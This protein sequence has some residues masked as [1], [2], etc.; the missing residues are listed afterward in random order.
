MYFH[1]IIHQAHRP[2][3]AGVRHWKCSSQTGYRQIQDGGHFGGC[4][5][6]LWVNLC[7][8]QLFWIDG[9]IIKSI[10]LVTNAI[11][12]MDSWIQLT[13]KK[14]LP[15]LCA[16]MMCRIWL[17]WLCLC[18]LSG[19]GSSPGQWF[20][21]ARMSELLM[22]LYM[23]ADLCAN[24]W[25]WQCWVILPNV[26]IHIHVSQWKVKVNNRP[27]L[28]RKRRKKYRYDKGGGSGITDPMR[29]LLPEKH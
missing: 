26:T 13:N 28:C 3:Y 24:V 7:K 11:S 17:N 27:K 15:F 9:I 4:K 25:P 29:E 16:V 18:E 21:V 22:L 8:G 12:F 6:C 19:D 1:F 2:S 5:F 20:K 14:L 10:F 23:L